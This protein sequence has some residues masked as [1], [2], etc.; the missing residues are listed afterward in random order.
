MSR[1]PPFPEPP[2]R[3][4]YREPAWVGP[5]PGVLPGV[6]PF[7]CVILATDHVVVSAAGFS[8]YPEGFVVAVQALARGVPGSENPFGTGPEPDG[9]D[10]RLHI[11]FAFADGSTAT[12]FA[13]PPGCETR[14]PPP[15]PV[16][17][18]LR[19]GRG[20]AGGRGEWSYD[21]WVWPLPPPG[22][23]AIVAEWPAT[24]IPVTRR[25][26]DAQIIRDAAARAEIVFSD[27]HLP[28]WPEPS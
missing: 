23:M 25:A 13:G 10:E 21:L 24:G 28:L 12:A 16:A 26:L 20:S 22:T 8:V 9:S 3:A 19:G 14:T 11:G 18:S 17:R 1:V 15:G 6:V 7:E 4:R 2:E 5:P 27:A